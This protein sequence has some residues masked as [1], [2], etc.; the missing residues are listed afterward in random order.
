MT[1][2]LAKELKEAGFPQEGEGT[3]F[4][5]I[6][7]AGESVYAPPLHVLI[8]ACGVFELKIYENNWNN[9]RNQLGIIP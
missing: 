1:Y 8:E 9:W 4:P 6:L 7:K 3:Y 5:D 2:E